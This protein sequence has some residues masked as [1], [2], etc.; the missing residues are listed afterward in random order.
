MKKKFKVVIGKCLLVGSVLLAVQACKEEELVFPSQS[1]QEVVVSEKRPTARPSSLTY[2][3]AFNQ[4]VE[5]YFPQLS[6]RVTKATITYTDGTEKKLELTKFE[7]P[8][9]IHLSEYKSYDFAIQYFTK[10]GTSSK[11]T[12]TVL[13]PLPYEVKYKLDNIQ[14][15][16]IDGGVKFTFPK[17]LD[18]SLKYTITYTVEGEQRTKNVEGAAVESITID[19]LL[20]ETKPISFKLTIADAELKVEA[21]KVIEQAPGALAEFT[22]RSNWIA[23]VSDSQIDDGGGAQALIDNDITSF[24]HS[25]Y[26]PSVPFPHW[27][28]IDFGKARFISK[29][30]MIRR[31]G[32]S[33]G[34]IQYD[35]E[36][37]LDGI[38]FTKVA[39][40]LSFDPTNS[41]WQYYILPKITNGR[42]IRVTM[43]KPKDAGDD[44]T[45][46]GEFKAFGY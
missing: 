39:S 1:E 29:I 22:D 38:T 34:F 24:W 7:E 44:F 27:F 5:I 33:N 23:T 2:I 8:V 43:T 11:V 19:K 13:K 18:R 31:S 37:S 6:D 12:T 20:D 45:H 21:S 4:N 26:D 16:P 42:Y 28:K 36:T 30:G 9:I 25:Q 3:F 15:E 14:S 10:D 41:N 46:L 35:L 32:A 40:N 17:T